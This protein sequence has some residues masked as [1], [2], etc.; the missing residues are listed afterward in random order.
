MAPLPMSPCPLLHLAPAH[1]DSGSHFYW[2]CD[3][4]LH[5]QHLYKYT[6]IRAYLDPTVGIL[7][8]EDRQ[9]SQAENTAGNSLG[10]TKGYDMF[11]HKNTS[12]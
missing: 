2:I 10:F 9:G 1:C 6:I 5:I 4:P 7:L 12:I 8:W 3:I 11:V